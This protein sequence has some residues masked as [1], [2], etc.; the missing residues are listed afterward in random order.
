M[1]WLDDSGVTDLTADIKALADADYADISHNHDNAYA[2]ISHAVAASTYGKGTSSNYGHVLLSDSTSSTTAA[3]SGGTAATP[4]AVKDAL[5]DAKTLATFGT[6]QSAGTSGLLPAP[7]QAGNP[8]IDILTC[9]GWEPLNADDVPQLPISKITNLQTTLD[10]KAPSGHY[11]QFL[12]EPSSTD[13][14]NRVMLTSAGNLR[15]DERAST[16]ESYADPASGYFAMGSQAPSASAYK[17]A[18]QVYATPNGSDGL[19]SM[20]S[21]VPDDI[22]VATTWYGTCSTAAATAAK[23]V[24]CSGF[25]L[26]TGATVT[27]YH[28]TASTV[29][30]SSSVAI[31]LNV[32]STGAKNIAMRS[33]TTLRTTAKSSGYSFHYQAGDYITYMYDGTYWVVIGSKKSI[34]NPEYRKYTKT[35]ASVTSSATSVTVTQT[36]DYGYELWLVTDPR[37]NGWVGSPYVGSSSFNANTRSASATIWWTRTGGGTASVD[38]VAKWI[39]M[40]PNS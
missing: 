35:S 16:S 34:S 15:L 2:P 1:A 22:P 9:E 23:V 10:G 29:R 33:G 37:T 38:F 24:T 5:D 4:K 20:R 39:G 27:V 12:F 26:K 19:P 17:T 31:T 28:S 8:P 6:A 7:P 11:H 21:L 14:L 25:V 3:A 32:N 36:I 18:N 40:A 13:N 30:T